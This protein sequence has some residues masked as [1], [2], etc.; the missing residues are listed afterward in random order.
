MD[1]AIRKPPIIYSFFRL[2]VILIA[3]LMNTSS[4]F[5]PFSAWWFDVFQVLTLRRA[6]V[7]SF[8][9]Y[10]F[11]ARCLF[12]CVPCLCLLAPSLSFM[13]DLASPTFFAALSSNTTRAITRLLTPLSGPT[14]AY[15]SPSRLP[16][17]LTSPFYIFIFIGLYI[18]TC[19]SSS[20][21]QTP[22]QPGTEIA[23]LVAGYL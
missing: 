15:K 8:L 2:F 13:F 16:C 14:M 19:G 11:L 21:A 23:M 1:E 5:L 18:M 6:D 22:S 12:G 7:C 17:P 10:P 9:L 3:V 4:L 20:T